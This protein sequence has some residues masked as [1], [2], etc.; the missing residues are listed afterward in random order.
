MST[1][2]PLIP[3]GTF[4]A[5]ATK[6]ASN[7][8]IAVATIIAIHVV[9]F[10][11]LLLQGCKKDNQTA[12]NP[13]HD[14]NTTASSTNYTLPPINSDGLYSNATRVAADTAAT[15]TSNI[16]APPSSTVA[17]TLGSSTTNAGNNLVNRDPWK[18]NN[19]G[20]TG[21]GA[22]QDQPSGTTKEYTVAKGDTLQKIATANGVTLSALRKANPNVD[23]K[24]L[25][26]NMKLVI[27]AA[28]TSSA[29]PPT[30]NGSTTDASGAAAAGDTYTVK[31][32]D[33]LTKIAKA[34]HVTTSE[35]RAANNLKT[36]DIR[37]NQKLKIPAP[38][39]GG[40]NAAP[41]T[42]RHKKSS[43]TNTTHNSA[44]TVPPPPAQ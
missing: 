3:Q 10:G 15:Q 6:G 12:I 24:K 8:R 16:P 37:P 11:G 26:A 9:F 2:N 29:M 42:A 7:V 21:A 41:N 18:A 32:G 23:P 1:P 20:T 22:T 27:P 35:L 34:H 14:T 38:S 44:G 43:G 33:T 28:A 39:A 40:T 13:G 4:Q 36:A 30:S 25:H 19:L 17:D 31:Q 5:Q